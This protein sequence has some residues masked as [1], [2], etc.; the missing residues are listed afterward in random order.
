MDC[1]KLLRRMK[2]MACGRL[3]R[4]WQHA[5]LVRWRR[6]PC[7]LR[8]RL[9][10]AARGREAQLGLQLRTV[11]ARVKVAV[12]G[13][14]RRHL[15]QN[16]DPASEAADNGNVDE[17][18]RLLKQWVKPQ[19]RTPPRV[20]LDSGQWART[21]NEAAEQWRLQYDAFFSRERSPRALS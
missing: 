16:L 4:D 15:Q 10:A 11:W 20:R 5:A 19:C 8:E 3:K 7:P 12:R 1:V 14:R 13:D 21:P 6:A 17:V 18:Y 9:V 2:S